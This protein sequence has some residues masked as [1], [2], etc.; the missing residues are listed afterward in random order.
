MRLQELQLGERYAACLKLLL[1]CFLFCYYVPAAFLITCFGLMLQ[2][3][4]DRFAIFRLLQRPRQMNHSLANR[5][6]TILRWSTPFVVAGYGL[7][8]MFIANT[9]GTRKVAAGLRCDL[10]GY[11]PFER[12][13][14]R[15]QVNPDRDGDLYFTCNPGVMGLF[16]LG[17]V[18]IVLTFFPI[19]LA[20]AILLLPFRAIGFVLRCFGGCLKSL[21]DWLLGIKRDKEEEVED[22][23]PLFQDVRPRLQ[24]YVPPLPAELVQHGTSFRRARRFVDEERD[25]NLLSKGGAFMSSGIAHGMQLAERAEAGQKLRSLAKA[26]GAATAS[27]T[28]AAA[29]AALRGGKALGSQIAKMRATA[30]TP[31]ERHMSTGGSAVPMMEGMLSR[32][33]ATEEGK[34]PPLH[35]HLSIGGTSVPMMEDMVL[36][37]GEDDDDD[38]DGE[39][40]H[41]AVEKE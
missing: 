16:V 4:S 34:R 19:R 27:G 25:I 39:E 2:Y 23:R 40:E 35:K 13:L 3:A 22:D 1:L 32:E 10:T 21:F 11:T 20:I 17:G 5:V 37:E 18:L 6:K 14:M 36:H 8:I 28:A 9:V 15:M 7:T 12:T 38:D 24:M 31:R 30:S 29:R 33:E 26:T 41:A